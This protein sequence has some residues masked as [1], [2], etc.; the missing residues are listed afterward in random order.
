MTPGG[1]TVPRL[2]SILATIAVIIAIA[3]GPAAAQNGGGGGAT[4]GPCGYG[5]YPPCKVANDACALLS[6]EVLA[7]VLGKGWTRQG[8]GP[9]RPLAG[10]QLINDCQ[11]DGTAEDEE[12]I[13]AV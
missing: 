2:T 8:S 1:N 12:A 13:L 10:A 5:E 7:S 4:N 11:Y 3:I 9:M 6:P